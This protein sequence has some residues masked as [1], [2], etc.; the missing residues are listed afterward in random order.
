[1]VTLRLA[2]A[3]LILEQVAVGRGQIHVL[4]VAGVDALIIDTA[5]GKLWL[6]ED[7]ARP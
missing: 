3:F 5:H 4:H 7:F 6:T 2:G 1:M